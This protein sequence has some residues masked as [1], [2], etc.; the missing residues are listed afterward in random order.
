MHISIRTKVLSLSI[1]LVVLTTVTISGAYYE[2]A[3]RAERREFQQRIQIAF[4]IVLDGLKDQISTYTQQF[5]DY[6]QKDNRLGGSIALFL[7][8]ENH[9]SAA[10]PIAFH[11]TRVADELKKVQTIVLADRLYLYGHDRRLLV[12]YQRDQNQDN[13]GAYVRSQTGQDTYL[14]LDDPAIQTKLLEGQPIADLPLPLDVPLVYAD[15]IPTAISAS[16]CQVG[17]KLGFRITIPII[18]LDKPTG[19]LVSEVFSTQDLIE[20]YAALSKTRINLFAGNVWSVGTF[21]VQDHLTSSSLGQ[22]IDCDTV[23][24]QESRLTFLSLVFDLQ[25]Y[26]QGQCALY[27]GAQ[28]IGAITVSLSQAIEQQEIHNIMVV[29][30]VIACLVSAIAVGCSLLF[31]HNTVHA[32]HSLVNIIG[33]TAEGDL[34]WRAVATTHDEIG[35]LATKL[36]QMVFQL[37][38][39]SVRVQ[40]SVDA[41]NRSADTILRQMQALMTHM[42]Q[43]AVSIDTTTAAMETITQ[44]IDVVTRNTTELLVVAAHNLSSVQETRA[45]IAE[46]TQ[47]TSDLTHDVSRISAAVD[48]VS[49][50]VKKISEHTGQLEAVAQQTEMEMAHIEHSL[51]EVSRNADSSQQLAKETMDAAAQGQHSVEASMQGMQA[52]KEVVGEIA[53]IIERI[54]S[55]SEQ[56]SSIL[57]IVDDITDQT[58][59]LSL[60]AA[61][62]SAQAGEHGRGFA[63]V[64]QE[65]KELAARTQTSTREIGVLIHEL[66]AST[67]EGVQKTVEGIQKADQG[68][69][70]AQTAQMALTTILESATRASVT[71]TNT[72]QVT[73]QTAASSQTV[74]TSMNHLIEMVAHIRQALQQED[75]DV[76]D[77][78][79]AVDDIRLL[80]ENVN[81]ASVEE[82]RS[83]QEIEDRMTD[84]TEKFNHIAEQT[85][86]LK[87][88]ADDIVAAMYDVETTV[89]EI[90][91]D[92]TVISTE[93][94]QQLHAQSEQLQQVVRVFKVE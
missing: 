74:K 34:R 23:S 10:R 38:G 21:P 69:T 53:H 91:S 70:L 16:L 89:A 29:I 81:Q 76:E 42:E 60:N 11:L 56:V 32:I 61:I 3:R 47:Y 17:Q 20:R 5:D 1:F 67:R 28:P 36:N 43:Q 48:Q 4:E 31:S 25:K 72:A 52:V 86:T 71:A 35:L 73:Q 50:S 41:V 68:V 15:E 46:V 26:Y 45:S 51:Q 18:Y 92:V 2:M 82:I 83:T 75:D 30:V 94:V 93:T 24:S 14:P 66:Q 54:R 84:I 39:I 12:L 49:Q 19:I 13:I 90:L 64:A 57:G 37:R 22:L 62:I 9:L 88:N 8:E 65:I 77:V 6:F 87:Q 79:T 63:V 33:A 85:E 7:Q 40:T 58:A 80:A 44:F 55:R 78:V 27:R 59:L